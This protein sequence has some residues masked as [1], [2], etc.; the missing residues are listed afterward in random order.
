MNLTASTRRL[1]P[2]IA[3]LAVCF[4]LCCAIDLPNSLGASTDVRAFGAAGDGKTDDTAAI[5]R[6][7]NAGVGGVHFSK[8]IYRLTQPVVINLDKV[9]FTSLV[10]DGTGRIV[11]AGAGP[12]FQLLGTHQGSAD[13]DQFKPNVWD[14]QRTPMVDAVEI[15]GDHREADGIE[16]TGTMQLTITRVVLR[17]LRHGIRLTVRN[18][19][20]LIADSHIYD[21]RG[22]GVFYDNVNLHQSS[23]TGCHISYC[24]GGGVVSRG[25]N[26]RNVQIGNCDIESNMSP[27]TPPTANVLLD[28]TGGSIGEVAITGCTIQHHSPSPDSANIRILGQGREPALEKRA[29]TATTQ[30]GHVTLTGNVLS[31]VQ[32]N[33]HIRHARGVTLTGN[34]FW[35]GYQHDLLVEESSNIVIGPNNFDRNPRY[36]YGTSLDA[37]GGLVFR[38]SK[39]CLLTGLHVN[40]VWR[41]PAALLIE[42]C[43]RFNVSNCSILDSDNVGLLMKDSTNTRVSGCVIR[44]GRKEKKG[45]ESLKAVGGHGNWIVQNMLGDSHDVPEGVARAEG[46][47]GAK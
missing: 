19:N 7:V 1:S 8:G 44:D 37:N 11:M 5:Q 46:N 20:V 40:G 26:V 22:I 30:E 31:D 25:G 28:S 18:R 24:S 35:M 33:V 6:A 45:T 38:N 2:T 21:N 41:K 4:R 9:G 10:G 43:D 42:A 32:I 47:Y 23:I 29:G 17:K 3:A 27:N 36:N 34:T 13:P 39:D 14:R 12:A 16:A 15:V